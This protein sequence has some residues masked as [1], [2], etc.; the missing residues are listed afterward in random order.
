MVS[1][2]LSVDG[3]QTGIKM[4]FEH[5]DETQELRF[6]GVQ[7]Q[8]PVLP[9]LARAINQAIAEHN[10]PSAVI[11]VGTTGLVKAEHDARQLFEL[12]DSPAT[13]QI[14]LAHDSVTSYLGALGDHHGV[15]VAAGTGVVTLAVGHDAVARVD[16]WGH[17]MGDIGSGYWIG[18][19]A[20]DAAMRGFDGRGPATALTD[21]LAA[22]WPDLTEAYIEL[23]AMP[24]RVATVASFAQVAADL[25][26]TDAIAAQICARAGSELANSAATAL[27]RVA[28][29]QGAGPVLVAGIGGV[30]AGEYVKNSFAQELERLIPAAQLQD[31]S[32]NGLDG[33]QRLSRLPEDHA[34]QELV[35][36]FG[37]Q[38]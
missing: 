34:L 12:I 3:G 38:R 14:A 19:Q 31:S 21:Q 29:A 16:G 11:S 2:L 8:E 9:Q 20:M 33:A 26:A 6:P 5:G 1:G 24:E 25:A 15:V 30:L 36:R 13:G 23:Q 10:A 4:R 7:T 35:S 37:T 22:R 27:R 32:G 17:I 28:L 18:Q